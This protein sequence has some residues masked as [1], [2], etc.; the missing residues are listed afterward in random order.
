MTDASLSGKRFLTRHSGNFPKEIAKFA[1][2]CILEEQ[3]RIY[4]Y[5]GSEN[6]D[7]ATFVNRAEVEEDSGPIKLVHFK[8]DQGCVKIQRAKLKTL[9]GG[10]GFVTSINPLE[11]D[12]AH[13]GI[14][15]GSEGNRVLRLYNYNLNECQRLVFDVDPEFN[16]TSTIDDTIWNQIAFERMR[17]VLVC[18]NIHN[19]KSLYTIRIGS[20]EARKE[21]VF[22]FDG[23]KGFD[24]STYTNNE[25]FASIEVLE[26]SRSGKTFTFGTPE[27]L[28]ML[29]V[30]SASVTMYKFDTVD[31]YPKGS[32]VGE[33]PKKKAE[34]P[35]KSKEAMASEIETQLKKMKNMFLDSSPNSSPQASARNMEESPH[36]SKKP[37]LLTPTQILKRPV[38]DETT[39]GERKQSKNQRMG[40]T[41]SPVLSPI[42]MLTQKQERKSKGKRK[43]SESRKEAQL[44]E[45]STEG[46][47]DKLLK[48]FERMLNDRCGQME[49]SFQRKL[50]ENKADSLK[51]MD[52]LAKSISLQLNGNIPAMLRSHVEVVCKDTLNNAMK[53]HME[54][55]IVPSFEKAAKE[56]FRQMN[57]TFKSGM[58]HISSSS[59]A[60]GS[61]AKSEL[62]TLAESVKNIEKSLKEIKRKVGKQEPK[63][64]DSNNEILADLKTKNFD[65][66][67]TKALMTQNI[68][69]VVWLCQ[70]I[71]EE[72]F[73]YT[74]PF[75]LSQSVLLALL[76]Q[77]GSDLHE[78]KDI[79]LSW[80][81]RISIKLDIGYFK[82]ESLL[83][84]LVPVLEEVQKNLNAAGVASNERSRFEVVSAVLNSV[85][86]MVDSHM[87]V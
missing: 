12:K 32:S 38:D 44:S 87:K 62:Q 28:R 29:C 34:D 49:L 21:G 82:K 17:S 76:Q 73:F 22:F 69:T 66:A 65:D 79:K 35:L 71:K 64:P 11:L 23:M 4:V 56:M 18:H 20:D 40:D 42:Q 68:E 10:S 75:P 37:K 2:P 57:T 85:L 43:E 67:F 59:A 25:I 26:E 74:D 63:G 31:F 6:S 45:G 55:I 70:Q 81:Q 61:S 33:E 39:S 58:K 27:K 60:S 54:E 51:M 36:E 52:Q 84:H 80:I 19:P 83:P 46:V 72:D 16:P 8:L 1:C 41:K 5:F 78:N 77:L 3:G 14:L 86:L 7:G 53:T 48:K 47:D 30:G 9:T 50:E 15:V 13:K 24:L